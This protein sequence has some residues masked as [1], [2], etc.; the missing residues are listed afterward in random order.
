MPRSTSHRRRVR[1]R[2]TQFATLIATALAVLATPTAHAGSFTV[3]SCTTPSGLWTGM[4]GWTSAA[5][6]ASQAHDP[7]AT[8]ECSDHGEPFSLQYGATQAPVTAGQWLRWTFAAAADTRIASV[9]VPRDFTLGWPVLANTYGRPYVYDAWH[10]S[11]VSNNQLE[12][13]YPPWNGTTAGMS[14]D[15]VLAQDRV[16]WGSLNLRL[17]CWESLGDHDCG[18][19]RASVSIPRTTITLTDNSD[20]TTSTAGGNLAGADPVRGLG[21][22]AFHAADAGAGVYRWIVAVDGDEVSRQIVDANGGS[23]ADA[24]PGDDDAYEFAEPQPCPLDAAGEAQLDTA[25]LQDGPHAL[26]VSVEDAAGNVDVVRDAM[27]TTH[28]API[29]TVAPQLSGPT[30]VGAQLATGDGQWDGAPTGF[31]YRWL[32]CDPDGSGCTGIAGAD[33]ATYTPTSADA[34][35]RLLAEV[36]AENPSGVAT[37]RSAASAPIADA[38]GRTTPP[39]TGTG[40]GGGTTGGTGETGAG[41]GIDG[42]QNPLGQ[43]PGH[44]SNGDEGT[45][46]AHL[47]LA[48]RRTDGRA[49]TRVRSVRAHAWT[50]AGRLLDAHGDGIAGARLNVAWRVDG[51]RW[52]AHGSVRTDGDGRFTT[53]LPPGPSRTVKLAYFPFSDSRTFVSSNVVTEDVLAPVAIHADPARLHGT[54]VVRLAG[55]VGGELI[56]RGGVLVTLQGFQTGWGWRTFRTVRTTRRGAF[57]TRYRFRLAHGRFGFRAVVP[58]QGSYP[59][60]TAHSA[61][62]YV[63]VT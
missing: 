12:F 58:R 7:G 23:C 38:A 41:T 18:P 33:G 59:F 9:A 31:G 51:R 28:N 24:E 29:S 8:L 55:Q 49:A 1:R 10:D 47:T 45:A 39:P 32:R 56:P 42:L 11:D 4:G 35:H 22:L 40:T 26:R 57:A 30:H 50:L 5:S 21:T 19:F 36:T 54:R 20:P 46:T 14:F 61:P 15:P 3:Y 16:A 60:V 52:S 6:S 63:T 25:A 17:R 13:F 44:V 53:I 48:F 43:L 34:Y 27:I 37:A 62:V 2:W